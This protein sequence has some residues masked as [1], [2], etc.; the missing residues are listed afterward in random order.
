MISVSSLALLVGALASSVVA[1]PAHAYV[2]RD[3]LCGTTVTETCTV[4]ETPTCSPTGAPKPTLDCTTDSYFIQGN[5]LYTVNLKTGAKETV[6][7]NVGGGDG[8]VNSLG[9]NIKENFLYGTQGKTLVRILGDGTTEK[10]ID[11]PVTPNI[12]DFD[13]QGNYYYSATGT[14]WG[15]VDLDP[16][17]PTYGTLVETGTSTL[18]NVPTP[19]DW[20]YTPAAPG[21]FYGVGVQRGGI[22]T[23]VRWS[24]TTHKWETVYTTK[25]LKA[26]AFGGVA[27]TSDGI[28]YGSDNASGGIFRFPIDDANAAKKV[29]TGPANSSNDGTRCFS[30]PDS[31]T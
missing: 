20:A 21:Y 14:S 23:L 30:N 25:G 16:A 10:V 5:T 28:I 19:S 18:G 24:V 1:G 27:S 22:P 2:G 31:S 11:L 15:R 6:S 13:D 29:A 4:T 9:F 17:S 7:D 3:A 8:N 12:G 26:Q